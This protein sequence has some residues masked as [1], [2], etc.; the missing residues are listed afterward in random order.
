MHQKIL[1]IFKENIHE[2]GNPQR[3]EWGPWGFTEIDTVGS[4]PGFLMADKRKKE[5]ASYLSH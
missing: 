4:H 2:S 3:K 5:E 1:K